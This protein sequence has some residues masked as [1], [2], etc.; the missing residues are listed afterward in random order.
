MCNGSHD[1]SIGNTC[2]AIRELLSPEN[3]TELQ[4]FLG[5]ATYMSTYVPKLLHHTLV[6]RELLK[7]DVEFE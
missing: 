4:E 7:S 3:K 2:E 5:I 1:I 6:L